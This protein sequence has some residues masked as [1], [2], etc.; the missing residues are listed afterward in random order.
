[1]Y[2]RK[3]EEM[4]RKAMR[5]VAFIAILVCVLVYVL[6]APASLERYEWKLVTSF[7]STLFIT[8]G[9]YSLMFKHV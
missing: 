3:K 8:I 1:M 7:D 6:F 2:G 4:N 9:G 5:V